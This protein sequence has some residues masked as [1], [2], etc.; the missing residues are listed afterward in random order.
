MMRKFFSVLALGLLACYIYLPG[1][2]EHPTPYSFGGGIVQPFASSPEYDASEPQARRQLS[3][4]ERLNG[5][6]D[7]P[8]GGTGLMWMEQF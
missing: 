8:V 3:V 6:R 2:C 1:Q 5:T 7:A 4:D